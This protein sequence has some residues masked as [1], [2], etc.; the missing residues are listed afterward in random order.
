MINTHNGEDKTRLYNNTLA[1]EIGHLMGLNHN[2]LKFHTQ[3]QGKIIRYTTIMHS[4]INNSYAFAS[5]DIEIDN[6][7]MIIENENYYRI[8]EVAAINER[9]HELYDNR[10]INILNKEDCC[11]NNAEMIKIQ[12][13]IALM[14]QQELEKNYEKITNFLN[15]MKYNLYQKEEGEGVNIENKEE[16]LDLI[17][18]YKLNIKNTAN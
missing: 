16:I 11:I 15:N 17:N 13:A 3:K 12:G 5:E 6:R 9:L 8:N 1:H 4:I 2:N 7:P 10:K 14:P 18:F